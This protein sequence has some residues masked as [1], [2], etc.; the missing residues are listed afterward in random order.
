MLWFGLSLSLGGLFFFFCFCCI[1]FTFPKS[2]Q[3][4]VLLHLW[5]MPNCKTPFFSRKTC[6]QKV[7]KI[8]SSPVKSYELPERSD[9]FPLGFSRTVISPRGWGV[10]NSVAWKE[11]LKFLPSSLTH[12]LSVSWETVQT[13]GEEC[14]NHHLHIDG[15]YYLVWAEPSLCWALGVQ[16]LCPESLK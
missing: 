5:P 4:A 9:K 8:F 7:G 15:M 16:S 12:K 11:T 13:K 14:W 2:N 1:Y 10:L 3:Q 6:G